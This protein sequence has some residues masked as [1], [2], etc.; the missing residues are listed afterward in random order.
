MLNLTSECTAHQK[1]PLSTA[2]MTA[3]QPG[4]LSHYPCTCLILISS[5]HL[6]RS[7]LSLLS[8][9]HLSPLST[10]PPFLLL[11]PLSSSPFSSP[12]FLPSVFS[13]RPTSENFSQ[14]R[15]AL[16]INGMMPTLYKNTVLRYMLNV[17]Q[18]PER[19]N[20][21]RQHSLPRRRHSLPRRRH[22]KHT[23]NPFWQEI[24]PYL[25]V[26]QIGTGS[27]PLTHLLQQ[28]LRMVST[29]AQDNGTQ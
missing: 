22:A 23:Q 28:T 12:S 14:V 8:T 17:Q 25:C 21:W 19:S 3:P 4:A 16:N 5:P 9:L 24:S 27:F 18:R 11:L 10:P 15:R 2:T 13:T 29:T 6:L 1:A 26:L 7:L 20:M